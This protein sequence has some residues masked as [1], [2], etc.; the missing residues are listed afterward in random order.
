MRQPTEDEQ[1]VAQARATADITQLAQRPV[2]ALSGGEQARV[3]WARV[4]AQDTPIL[5]LD[6]PVAALDLRHQV[7]TM[8]TALRLSLIHI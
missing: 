1:I 7:A 4:L 5:I 8:T 6:E 2:Q 3:A